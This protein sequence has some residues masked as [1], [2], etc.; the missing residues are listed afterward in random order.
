VDKARSEIDLVARILNDSREV[1]SFEPGLLCEAL[2]VGLGLAGEK[3]LV[4]TK[5]PHTFNLPELS[6]T[7][8]NT[9]DAFRPR[10]SATRL[11]G[12]GASAR[13]AP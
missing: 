1:M 11:S 5:T 2:N 10:A 7:W 8:Q 9:L 3:P 4:P 6:D 13:C 12:T